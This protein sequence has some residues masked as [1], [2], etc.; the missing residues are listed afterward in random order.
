MLKKSE[1]PKAD[2][3]GSALV[4]HETD[5]NAG[6]RGSKQKMWFDHCQKFCWHTRDTC[7]NLHGKPQNLKKK[8][9][10]ESRAF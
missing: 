10:G 4:V 6:K 3:D 7:W 1:Q 8:W 2:V 5:Q 9:G